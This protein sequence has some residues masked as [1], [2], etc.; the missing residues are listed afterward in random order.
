MSDIQRILDT[1]QRLSE[2]DPARTV[3]GASTHQYCLN[4][5]LAVEDVRR[6]EAEH[7]ITLPGD[8]RA[9][10]LRAGDGGAGPYYGLYPLREALVNE[11]PSFLA[12]PFPHHLWW[13]DRHPP[14]WFALPTA[15]LLDQPSGPVEA[16]YFADE[17]V[18]GTL[19]LAHEG[20]GYYQILIVSDDERG[21]VWSDNRASDGGIAPV[22]F[23]EGDLQVDGVYL[24]PTNDSG[25]R[26]TFLEWY[27]NWLD[28]SLRSVG[29]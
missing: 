22:P 5:P 21:H 24:I 10:L 14:N 27:E 12:R 2:A 15:H 16:A 1:L 8:Y 25:K 3:F 18:R 29:A 4:A 26:L 9:F 7:G 19:R 6:F 17:H 20:C 13:N 23:P 28:A 11:D